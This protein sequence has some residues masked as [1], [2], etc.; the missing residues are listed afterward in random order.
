MRLDGVE[1]HRQACLFRRVSNSSP[2][3]LSLISW[4]FQANMWKE[5]VYSTAEMA[6]RIWYAYVR[7]YASIFRVSVM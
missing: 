6:I 3:M 5:R 4:Y 1:S 7:V 2:S